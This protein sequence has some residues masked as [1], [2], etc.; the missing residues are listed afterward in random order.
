L[1]AGGIPLGVNTSMIN[2]VVP[3]G[4]VTLKGAVRTVLDWSG[5]LTVVVAI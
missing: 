4:T 1:S 5:T 2:W 3:A